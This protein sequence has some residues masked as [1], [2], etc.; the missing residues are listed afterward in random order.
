M[1]EMEQSSQFWWKESIWDG[2]VSVKETTEG[3]VVIKI[4]PD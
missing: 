4:G 1:T 2:E 3:V